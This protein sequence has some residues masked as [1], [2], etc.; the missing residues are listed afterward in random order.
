[1]AAAALFKFLH[2]AACRCP[3]TML[4]TPPLQVWDAH[5]YLLTNPCKTTPTITI[6]TTL[7][8]TSPVGSGLFNITV[9]VRRTPVSNSDSQTHPC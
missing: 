5:Q 2:V 3:L 9:T 7:D 8:G 6:T 1:V 4:C